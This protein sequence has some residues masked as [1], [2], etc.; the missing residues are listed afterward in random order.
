MTFRPDISS[1][2]PRSWKRPATGIMRSPISR[3]RT[4][5]IPATTASIGTTAPISASAPPPI[6]STAGRRRWNHRSLDAY[7]KD[8]AAG[9][10]PMADSEILSRRTTASGGPLPRFSDARGHSSGG[11]QKAVWSGSAGGKGGNPE[12]ADGRQFGGDPE[13]LSDA[14]T[15]GDGRRRQPGLDLNRSS[16]KK[17]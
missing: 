9:K 16:G 8:L 17:P 4:A 13:R 7:L 11:L 2:P 12:K 1:G 6:P 14:D 3:G 5:S 10:P 15:R